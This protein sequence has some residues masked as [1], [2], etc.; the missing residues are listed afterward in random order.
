M[1]ASDPDTVDELQANV[2]AGNVNAGLVALPV[3]SP[4]GLTV[5]TPLPVADADVP[6]TPSAATSATPLIAALRSSNRI[7]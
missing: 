4:P 6:D 3:Y 5:H 1:A 2:A 7:T